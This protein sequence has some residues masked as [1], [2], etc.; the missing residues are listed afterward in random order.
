MSLSR[1]C[2]SRNRLHSI[3]FYC[4][5]LAS[6]LGISVSP[7]SAL[8]ASAQPPVVVQ[9]APDQ[10]P[11]TPHVI[12]PPSLTAAQLG[13]PLDCSLWPDGVPSEGYLASIFGHRI[14]S[15]ATDF[16]RGMDYRCRTD[17]RTCCQVLD[18]QGN[19]LSTDCSK[20][21]CDVGETEI[22]APIR[23]LVAGDVKSVG[24]GSG[25][26]NL[27]IETKLKAPEVIQ[28]GSTTCDKLFIW[29]Q[30]MRYPY[31]QPWDTQDGNPFDRVAQNEVLGQQGHSGANSVHLHLSVRACNN[32][33]LDANSPSTYADPE[34]NPFQLIGTDD[35]IAPT[36]LDL[37]TDLDGDDV[38]V[39]VQV[40]TVDP[41]FDQLEIAVYDAD[42]DQTTIRRLGYNSRLGIDVVNDIDSS[43]LEP[44]DLSELT[45]IV[46]PDPP[47]PSSGFTLVARF[48]NMGLV[49]HAASR[50]QIKVADVFG[51]NS[52]QEIPIFAPPVLGSAVLHLDSAIGLTLDG[53]G[54]VERWAD[55]SGH[56]HDALQATSTQRPVPD[57][58]GLHFGTDDAMCIPHASDLNP[59]ELT[60]FLVFET[61]MERN[62]AGLLTTMTFGSRQGWNLALRSPSLDDDT[63][64]TSFQG[65]GT[66]AYQGNAGAIQLDTPHL[67]TM[68]HSDPGTHLS[69]DAGSPGSGISSQRISYV[70][71]APLCLNDYYLD[72]T[73]AS[74]RTDAK[75][76]EIILFDSVLSAADE[77]AVATY[78]IDKW[79]ITSP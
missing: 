69:V 62:Y 8:P 45:M 33:R 25:N 17:G 65:D 44:F 49:P 40:A 53:S 21:S 6:M 20:K 23:A 29:Y 68:T 26:N 71:D 58:D 75:Y 27:V 60:V 43:T 63:F 36:I 52:L 18:H 50:V 67:L 14:S 72:F 3:A 22:P 7:A 76:K 51:N 59:D 31:A 19:V 5:I 66:S 41:D 74:L 79:G 38:V 54:Q 56:G 1:N 13:W 55:L 30:H 42:Q 34:I 10:S 61:A 28:V 24:D 32:S 70:A 46:E 57:S 9:G 47:E 4:L 37:Q 78:L 39:T 64:A 16:H 12:L 73:S 15:G 35:G 11:L 48:P 2:R 77:A